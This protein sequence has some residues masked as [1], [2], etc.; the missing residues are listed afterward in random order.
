M[1]IGRT[2]HETGPGTI[3]LTKATPTINLTKPG[4]PQGIVQV[5]LNWST[6]SKGLFRRTKPVDLDLGCLYELTDGNKGVIQAAGDNFGSLQTSPHIALDTDDRSGERAQGENLHIDL[7]RPE[8]FRR[9]LIFA[10]RYEGTPNWAA[11][12][13]VA[14]IF[15]TWGP[16]IEVRLDSPVSGAR[17]CVIA[18]LHNQGAGI[19]V[20]REV[21]YID[22]T[23]RDI[24]SAYRWGITWNTAHK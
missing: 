23:Q 6:R 4:E 16:N 1:A 12:D 19:T 17:S 14:T 8:L 10:F 5:N 9:I 18:L 24:D 3:S 20:Q 2:Q 7:A 11:A 21:H 15:P 22:G 13:A